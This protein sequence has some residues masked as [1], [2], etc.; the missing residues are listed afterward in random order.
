MSE[1][2]EPRWYCFAKD[3]RAT[4]CIDKEDAEHWKE[5][6]DKSFPQWAPHRAVQLIDASEVERLKAE[7]DALKTSQKPTHSSFDDWWLANRVATHK[8]KGAE[9]F[10]RRV[11]MAAIKAGEIPYATPPDTTALLEQVLDAI[12][13]ELSPDW[14]CNSHHPK[15]HAAFTAIKKHLGEV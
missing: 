11:W 4:L 14:E 3:G 1:Q 12:D 5:Y 8:I 13:T 6:L 2:Q 7:I 9:G 15:M 10:A